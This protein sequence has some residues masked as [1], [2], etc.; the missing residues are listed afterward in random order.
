MEDFDIFTDQIEF[1]KPFYK[2]VLHKLV[3]EAPSTPNG[4]NYQTE[5]DDAKCA[6]HLSE[7]VSAS[8]RM[9]AIY[10]DEQIKAAGTHRLSNQHTF[11]FY[12]N[13]LHKLVYEAPS[14]PNGPNYQTEDDDAKCAFHLSE[15]VSASIRMMAVYRDEQIKAAEWTVVQLTA[16]YNPQE[17][18][19]PVS[20]YRKEMDS[21]YM[22]VFTNDYM[23]DIGPFTVNELYSILEE[24]YTIIDNAQFLNNKRL[25]QNYWSRRED[26][27]L[28]M[29]SV[30]NVMDQHWLG[31]WGSLLTGRL[32]DP[33]WKSRI[34]QLVDNAISDWGCQA[35]SSHQIKSC[36]R[37]IL[38]EHGNL[39]DVRQALKPCDSCT[40]PFQLVNELC[41]KCQSKCF[42][43]VHNFTVAE[44]IRAFYLVATRVK[45]DDEW[46]TLKKA[47]RHPVILIVDEMLDT[48]PWESL[49]VLKHHPVTRIENIHFLYY[50][51]K[52]H[53]SSMVD[54]YIETS[55]QVG[56]YVIN[57]GQSDI[58]R[59]HTLPVLS[60]QDPPEQYGGRLHRDERTSGQIRHQP[61]SVV[62]IH[63][64]YYL[65]KTYLSSM[66]DG[67]IETS[68]Q[69]G[70]YVINPGAV[71]AKAVCILSG[72]GSVRLVHEAGRAPPVTDLEVDKVVTTLLSLYVPSDAAVPWPAVGKGKWSLGEL[73]II[74]LIVA[75]SPTVVGMLWEVTDLEVDKV[76]T[77]LLSLYVPSDAAVP[78]HAVGK[79][80]WSLGE[81]AIILLIVACSPTVVGMLW[82]VTDLEV[83][84]V[85]TTLLSLYAPSDAAVP[86]PAVGKGKWNRSVIGKLNDINLSEVIRDQK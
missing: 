49:P 11:P 80:K 37:R 43:R 6:F 18:L 23:D 56:R 76:V 63:F 78:W 44:G 33:T 1:T 70:R 66:V 31:G 62:N 59:E 71:G 77:T 86:W 54:G 34:V 67:Y 20:E 40:D 58:R 55:G 10:R 73:A 30:I 32:M 72:C 41:L 65:Y 79:G 28:R 35:L 74:L 53:L 27:D 14:T 61:R 5:D 52:T 45:E 83:D 19:K 29:M 82:E 50:L 15:A 60:V 85:V 22:S 75:C 24:N 84:K 57:P 8:I 46:T 39:T 2:N 38:T 64:L 16:P 42:E 21:I 69:V 47:K 12:K 51:Y 17:N 68:G 25:V 36:I 48:F 3:Y 81:L 13:V 26:I 9:M 7:A 4:P